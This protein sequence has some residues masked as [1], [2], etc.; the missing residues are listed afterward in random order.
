MENAQIFT[1]VAA[2]VV[3]AAREKGYIHGPLATVPELA[4]IEKKLF[5]MIAGKIN[6]HTSSKDSAALEQD[7]MHSLFIYVMAKAAEAV[8]CYLRHEDFEPEH[9]GMFDGKVPVTV[10]GD[11]IGEMKK[12]HLADDMYEAFV[13]WNGA[14][15]DFCARQNIHPVLPLLEALKWTFRLAENLV[16][17][18]FEKRQPEA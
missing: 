13:E 10:E 8:S 1:E 16:I 3:K 17:E 15:P 18:Y 5:V 4:E 9:Y 7:E 2:V 14:N 12:M 6:E 11:L